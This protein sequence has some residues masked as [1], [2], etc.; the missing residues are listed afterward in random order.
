MPCHPLRP[1]KGRGHSVVHDCAMQPLPRTGSQ[2]CCTPPP[3]LLLLRAWCHARTPPTSV[4]GSQECCIPCCCCYVPG[5]T[6]AHSLL[7][8]HGARSAASPA[9]AAVTC[10]VPRP[11]T[12]FF[13]YTESG[14]LHPLL[15]GLG[16]RV[17]VTRMVPQPLA[18]WQ[19]LLPMQL[20]AGGAA[21]VGC[22]APL[23]QLA[24]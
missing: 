23:A 8:L 20:Q 24:S 16:F 11:H 12:A 15:L 10:L 7:S 2:E 13:P 19:V 22:S 3:L 14:V 4:T 21:V 17:A 6:P 9:A 5:A 1:D 18:Y